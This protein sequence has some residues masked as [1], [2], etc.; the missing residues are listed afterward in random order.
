MYT[1]SLTNKDNREIEYTQSYKM[2]EHHYRTRLQV[3]NFAVIFNAALLTA[4]QRLTNNPF[5][6]CNL[7]LFG[8]VVT[9]VMLAIEKRTIFI[10]DQY[11]SYIKRLEL[12]LS[13]SL[14]ITI[15]NSLKKSKLRTRNYFSSLYFVLIIMWL[16]QIIYSIF[17]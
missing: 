16:I 9:G 14:M 13:I 3:F 8:I 17:G 5:Q 12:E 6:K 7:S 2:I 1:N 15:D 11:I 4:V 10:V